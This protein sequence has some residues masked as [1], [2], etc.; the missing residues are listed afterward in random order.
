M[1]PNYLYKAYNICGKVRPDLKFLELGTSTGVAFNS[2]TFSNKYTVDLKRP[3]LIQE[4]PN[5]FE[6][7]TDEFFATT[8]L[9][10][11]DLIF[12]DA[13]HDSEQVLRDYNSSVSR[14]KKGGVIVLH[15][16][17]PPTEEYCE[18]RF[19]SDSYKILEALARTGQEVTFSKDDFGVTT[20][21]NAKLLDW[22]HVNYNLDYQTFV[23]KMGNQFKST[24]VEYLDLL[25]N[26]IENIA[27]L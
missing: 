21:T 4:H 19:C 27:K 26:L 18:P 8:E 6:Q 17:Y 1:T 20:V 22:R 12:I 15:D 23:T 10:D 2:L 5:S 9:T 24:E 14:L 13:N 7:S 3:D 11:F 16:C 25:L